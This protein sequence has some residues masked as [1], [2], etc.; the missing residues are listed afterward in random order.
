MA[1]THGPLTQNRW[2][3]I[4]QCHR[5]LANSAGRGWL[6]I[7]PVN[8]RTSLLTAQLSTRIFFSLTMSISKGCL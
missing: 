2:I 5:Y 3:I 7:L 6:I 1:H 8:L 4:T